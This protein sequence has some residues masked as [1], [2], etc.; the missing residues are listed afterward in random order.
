MMLRLLCLAL[1]AA[2]QEPRQLAFSFGNVQVSGNGVSNSPL[3]QMNS[4]W[5]NAGNSLVQAGEKKP[6]QGGNSQDPFGPGGFGG[7]P[8]PFNDDPFSSFGNTPQQQKPQ[9]MPV[10]PENGAAVLKG[11][12]RSFLANEKLQPGEEECLEQGCSALGSQA[13]AVAQNVVM[14]GESVMT[15]N[16]IGKDDNG[17]EPEDP[18]K[19]MMG[20]F[21]DMMKGGGQAPAPPPP[22]VPQAWGV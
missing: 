10:T 15:V 7:G 3:G 16:K 13:S 18:M 5:N 6:Q 20:G 2:A 12:I 1:P 9:G 4:V 19:A 21:S 22:A 14:I 8:T 17:K 11:M